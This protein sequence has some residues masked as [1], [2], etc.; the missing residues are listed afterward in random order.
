MEDEQQDKRT[1]G[2]KVKVCRKC[3]HRYPKEEYGLWECPECGEDRH[4]QDS[5][6]DNGKCRRAGG[7][8]LGGV[9]SPRAK[10]LR[11]SR[12][13]PRRLRP[14]FKSAAEDTEFLTLRTDLNF[15]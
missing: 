13:V 15:L 9:A 12:Y 1:C 5:P 11:H 6:M 2:H 10:T 8:S 14:A 3:A 7:K 4:C